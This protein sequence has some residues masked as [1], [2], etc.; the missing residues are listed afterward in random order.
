MVYF[1]FSQICNEIFS[2]MFDIWMKNARNKQQL[3]P[4]CGYLMPNF[5]FAKIE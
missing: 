3:L 2:H 5:F 4:R 1:A